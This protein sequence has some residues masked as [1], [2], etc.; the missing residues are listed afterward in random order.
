MLSFHQVVAS[1][2]AA[3]NKM[4][5]DELHSDVGLVENIGNYIVEGGGKRLRPL[6]VLLAA[7]ACGYT[8]DE[9]ITL[10]TIVEFIHT[11]TLL[12][13]DVV[14]RS[15][16]RR[17]RDTA[18]ALWGNSPTVLVGD[19]L[20]SRAFQLMVRLDNM[21]IMEIMAD[22]TNVIAEGEVQ[23]LV[24]IGNLDVDEAVYES[25]IFKK[26]AVLFQAAA[27]SGAALASASSDHCDAFAQYGYHLGM[28]FQLQDDVLDYEGN[29]DEMGKNLG[30]DLA[31]G[32]MTLPL[33]HAMAHGGERARNTIS[34][35]FEKADAS[36][37]VEISQ[38]IGETD[39]LRYCSSKAAD[40]ANSAKRCLNDIP[41]T[42]FRQ[43]LED[44][45]DFSVKRSY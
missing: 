31:E 27:R 3:V 43:T 11:A 4:I 15:D 26:T 23:Q 16:K 28:A 42:E 45:A 1:D 30:D 12:H 35:A 19:F 17:G 24:N 37:L 8:S 36:L 9:H 2:F 5:V 39:S 38:I 22:T 13:D 20:Y 6:T 40:H 29:A 25:T 34:R 44:I 21:R 10:A 32:K 14:D 33:I 7:K 41:M 18:N